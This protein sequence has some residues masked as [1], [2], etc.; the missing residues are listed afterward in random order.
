MRRYSIRDADRMVHRVAFPVGYFCNSDGAQTA[1]LHRGRARSRVGTGA[2]HSRCR[3]G[4]QGRSRGFLA[5]QRMTRAK[6]SRLAGT[7]V[8]VTAA[9]DKLGSRMGLFRKNQG[10]RDLR[11]R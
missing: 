10:A 6:F 11:S 3:H 9:L 7:A 2:V 1:A 8:Q 5:E 4:D